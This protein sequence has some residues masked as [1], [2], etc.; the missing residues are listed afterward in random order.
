MIN[1]GRRQPVSPYRTLS[2]ALPYASNG[3]AVPAR[4]VTRRPDN[5][6]WDQAD[7]ILCPSAQRPE[8]TRADRQGGGH[9]AAAE[10]ETRLRR[11]RA[12]IQ[13]GLDPAA[14]IEAI[15]ASWGSCGG[16]GRTGR[17]GHAG[18][19]HPRYG[20]R[21]GRPPRRHRTRAEL[22]GPGPAA[23]P[24]CGAA[25]EMTYDAEDRAVEV[26]IQP[27]GRGGGRPRGDL[28]TNHTP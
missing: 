17:H 22:G 24:A 6:E 15:N 9:E 8:R 11:L 20:L 18:R 1:S 27:A 16:T 4:R 10:A 12:A 21:D 5:C 13:A 14:L 19:H 26:G 23:R 25:L 7:G 3:K 2:V 28:H